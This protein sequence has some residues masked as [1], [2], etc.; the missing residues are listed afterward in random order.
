MHEALLFRKKNNNQVQCRLCNR[1]CTIP[2]N[3]TGTCRVRQN[4]E[5]GLYSLVYG[6]P[7]SIAIDP[8]EKKPLFHFLPGERALSIGTLGCNFFCKGCQN[9]TISRGE[10]TQTPTVSPEAVVHQAIQHKCKVIAF[11]YNEPTLFYE[12][13]ID[14]AK[15]ARKEGLRTCMVSNGYMSNEALRLL[16]RTVDAFNIDLKGF[17]DA[18]YQDYCK[19]CLEPVLNN[20][21]TIKKRAWLEITTLLIPGLND[22]QDL[23]R[24]MV[25]WIREQ[26]GQVP[27]HFSR[28]FPTY[29][30]LNYRETPMNTLVSAKRIAD[31]EL[32]Y[33]YVGNISSDQYAHTCCPSCN[34]VVVEREAYRLVRNN[35]DRDRCP[36]CRYPI[37]GIWT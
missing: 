18:F 25:R 10:I 4:R 35:L 17:S 13:L 24:G 16:V 29:Q 36:S 9:F 27:L 14:I 8:V 19:A 5:G 26:L 6:H 31:Q 3:A 23:L 15:K 28:F 11:T 32:D 7:C 30:A 2:E 21:V 12:Y 34:A 37:P 1:F 20:L 22:Q 33:V